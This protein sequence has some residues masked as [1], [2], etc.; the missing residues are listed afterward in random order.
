MRFFLS[1]CFIFCF[2]FHSYSKTSEFGKL[3]VYIFKGEKLPEKSYIYLQGEKKVL[4]DG[5][6]EFELPEGSYE[7]SYK[8]KGVINKIRVAANKTSHISFDLKK[9]PAFLSKYDDFD[10]KNEALNLCTFRGRV[11]SFETSKPLKDV[12]VIASG[13]KSQ[14][15]TN[16]KGEFSFET[17]I[18]EELSLSFVHQDYRLTFKKVKSSDCDKNLN[19]ELH[20]SMG[21]MKEVVVLAPKSKGSIEDLL[22]ERKDSKSVSVFIGS[23]QFKKN[24]D[25]NA[26][27]AL[28]RVSGLS[29]V[30][31][32]YVYIRG[33]G[34]RYS[35][36][37]LNGASLPSPN[38]TRRVVPLDLFPT[39]L[40]ESISIQKSYSVDKPAQFSAGLVE[41][42][43]LS[44]PKKSFF[45]VSLS[46]G[47]SSQ[48]IL[49]GQETGMQR[50]GGGRSSD[51]TGF[52]DGSRSLPSAI[53]ETRR[54][55]LALVEVDPFDFFGDGAGF[56]PEEL[57]ALGAS[58]GD[59]YDFEEVDVGPNFGFS[60]S[61]GGRFKS[62]VNK[63]GV[64]TKGVYSLTNDYEEESNKSYVISSAEEGLVLNDDATR[65]ETSSR[66]NLG[67]Q[68]SL[69][70]DLFKSQKI[71]VTA[72][73][74]RSTI[75]NHEIVENRATANDEDSFRTFRSFW[76][77]RELLN[78]QVRGEHALTPNEK[79]LKLEWFSSRSLSQRYRP[80]EIEYLYSLDTNEFEVRNF[81]NQR[82][83]SDLNDNANE[84]NVKLSSEFNI[85][86]NIGFSL[87]AGLRRFSKTRLSQSQR[88]TLRNE[89]LGDGFDSQAPVTEIL[90]DENILNQEFKLIDST[91][92]ADS[93]VAN[94]TNNAV[95]FNLAYNIKFNKGSK[96]SLI[97]GVRE[98]DHSQDVALYDILTKTIGDDSSV[99]DQKDQFY[100]YGAIYNI[101]EKSSITFAVSHTVARP[102]LQEFAPVVFYN[103]EENVLQMGNPDLE[104]SEVN[105]IDLRWDH[106][107]N[108]REFLSLGYFRKDIK[109]PIETVT[110][111]GPEGAQ[112]FVNIDAAFND[113]FEVEFR[114]HLI[115]NLF[116]SGNYSYISSS[117]DIDPEDIGASTNT[118]RPLQGQSPY[119]INVGLEYSNKKYG[120]DSGLSYNVAGRRIA[121]VGAFESPDI[122]EEPFDQLDFTFV[123]KLT[124]RQ[125]IGFKIQN[126]LDPLS[127]RTQG[128]LPTRSFKR[129]RRFSV[130]ISTSI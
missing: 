106:Y 60:V 125:R 54:Q 116:V 75:E 28:K 6:K 53:A 101:N 47:A 64:I 120:L 68:L 58:F 121:Q 99:L 19:V 114:K 81:G 5:F 104:I 115:R 87:Y 46:T 18:G 103:D 74:T 66:Y 1:F 10:L 62:G 93:Y 77:E 107:F 42:R 97:G 113:G 91:L 67:G 9:E 25:S 2:S 35:S 49:K 117:V 126:I 37:N 70:A 130:N 34:E 92:A 109:N 112:T 110:V 102:D 41:V 20:P 129:G 123:K 90:S 48:N 105:N 51:F 108:P 31:G 7:I 8:K 38:P 4:Y 21:E 14:S 43:T 15:L 76:E 83:F 23:E 39:S 82:I 52:D 59:N 50:E 3:Q 78:F 127:E 27:A 36:T 56:Q 79:A 95:F 26:A 85:H 94:E 71:D 16:S 96:L 80:D 84:F 22:K 124:K 12:A 118:D 111:P 61:S 119:L 65:F 33:L 44:I 86:E 128:G 30:E 24:G 100:N 69:G 32:R 29:L 45:N 57:S 40:I 63:F 13:T 73:A 98:E 55:G 72:L 11:K 17:K 89:G 122:Y 88:F